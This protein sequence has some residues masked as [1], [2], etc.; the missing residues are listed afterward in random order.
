MDRNSWLNFILALLG[1]YFVFSLLNTIFEGFGA[2]MVSTMNLPGN[3]YWL[4]SFGAAFVAALA[5]VF[6]FCRPRSP[7][8]VGLAIFCGGI[9]GM[10]YTLFTTIAKMDSYFRGEGINAVYHLLPHAAVVLASILAFFI[11][12][13][14]NNSESGG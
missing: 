6:V 12:T 11:I 14:T 10:Y 4:I 2:R 8:L 9:L 13:F 1:F 3:Y 5:L 7:L